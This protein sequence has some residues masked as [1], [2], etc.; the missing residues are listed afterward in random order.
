[1]ELICYLSN[2]Y[3]TI[4][5]S[6]EMSY[7]YVEAGCDI[8]EVDFPSRNP[9]LESDFI[10]DRMKKAL[11]V[12]DDY[13]LYMEGIKK[14][15]QN[16]P[17]TKIIL[18]AYE[19]TVEEIGVEKF[20]AYCKE[21]DLLDLIYVGLKDDSIKELLI[22]S[23]IRVS[24][25]VQYHLPVSEVN[26]AIL[27]NGFV[28]LQAKPTSNNINEK[29]PELKD[30]ITYL[31]DNEITRPIYCG[32]GISTEED[33]KHAK[34]SGS[35]A[36]FVGSAILKLHDDPKNMAKKIKSLKSMC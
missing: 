12:C 27:S 33:V 32:V 9:Y 2:G 21:N 14:I 18:L 34:D 8:I 36:V 7:K 23:G 26:S 19:N 3:P 15:K 20:I 29:Y 31:R 30:C 6:I 25:Y 11:E 22:K 17:N 1:M 10:K 35:D 5:S 16:L 24:C 28:Y 13:S 4:E